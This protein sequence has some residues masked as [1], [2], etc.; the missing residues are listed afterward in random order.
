[1]TDFAMHIR[2]NLT[3]DKNTKTKD[4]SSNYSV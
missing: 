1:M 2:D 3:I 4:F